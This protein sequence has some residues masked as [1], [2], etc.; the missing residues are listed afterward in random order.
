MGKKYFDWNEQKWTKRLKKL[1]K[2]HGN[3]TE[4]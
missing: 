2:R 3:N 4:G 1:K